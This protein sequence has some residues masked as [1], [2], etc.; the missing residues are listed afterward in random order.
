MKGKME[1]GIKQPL[2][3][4]GKMLTVQE[5][6]NTSK[7]SACRDQSNKIGSLIFIRECLNLIDSEY[8][9]SILNEAK[10]ELN[11]VIEKECAR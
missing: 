2:D 10:R 9:S 7:I 11:I 5:A 1:L 4:G 3:T 6:D 8:S